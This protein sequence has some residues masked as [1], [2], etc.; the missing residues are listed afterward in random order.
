MQDSLLRDYNIIEPVFIRAGSICE[1]AKG[2]PIY[3]IQTMTAKAALEMP[4]IDGGVHR[5]TGAIRWQARLGVDNFTQFRVNIPQEI[6]QIGRAC[7][8]IFRHM[9]A[10]VKMIVKIY[11]RAAVPG[12]VPEIFPLNHAALTGG[13]N[14]VNFAAA[15]W[16]HRICYI[17]R[18]AGLIIPWILKTNIVWCCVIVQYHCI[19]GHFNRI[20]IIQQFI[21]CDIG[22]VHIQKALGIIIGYADRHRQGCKKYNGRQNNKQRI[23]GL[24]MCRIF[25]SMIISGELF[26]YS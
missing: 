24:V 13:K 25:H 11:C 26:D 2:R 23:A 22:F 8:C 17:T 10:T 21:D 14:P 19:N 20:L 5:K 7:A 9:S 18:G 12:E 1:T 3:I 16:I 15:V 4:D 6:N